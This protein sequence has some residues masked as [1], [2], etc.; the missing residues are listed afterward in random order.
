MPM[1]LGQR[2]EHT[3]GLDA[4]FINSRQDLK[5]YLLAKMITH[6]DLFS[7]RINHALPI[8]RRLV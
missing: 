6:S 3:P 4:S 2:E 1:T 7:T 5:V 8:N